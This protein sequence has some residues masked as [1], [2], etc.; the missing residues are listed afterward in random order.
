M[1]CLLFITGIIF[2]NLHLNAQVQVRLSNTS[3]FTPKDMIE[4]IFLG[5]G[6]EVL[7]VKY[8][9]ENKSTGYFSNGMNVISLE[10]GIIM[11]TGDAAQASFP[12]SKTINSST[13]SGTMFKDSELSKAI[14]STELNDIS[15]FEI[16]F[17]P[18][19]DTISF[20]Y[21]FASEEYPGYSCDKYN[22]V[23]GFFISG[24]DPA[25]GFYE[26]KNVALIPGTNEAVSINN[27]HPAYLNNCTA[28]NVEFYNENP[29]GSH[30]MV[31]NGYLDVFSASARVVPCTVY[32]IKIAIADVVDNLYDSAVFLEAKSFSAAGMNVTVETPSYDGRIAEGCEPARITFKF[33]SPVKEDIN[34]NLKLI[35]DLTLGN[36]A[37]AIL[38]F[39]SIPSSGIIKKGDSEFSFNLFALNDNLAENEEVVAIEYQKDLCN[40]DTI[41]LRISDNKLAKIELQDSL[42]LCQDNTINVG[43][44]LPDNYFPDSEKF[45][46]NKKEY[47]IPGSKGSTVSSKVTVAN[48]YPGF[49]K[50]EM[51]KEICIDRLFG[52]NLYDLDIYLVSPDNHFIELSSDNGFRPGGVSSVDSMI[53]T[54]FSVNASQSINNGNAVIGQYFPLNPNYEGY[55][56]PEGVWQDLEGVKVNGDWELFFYKDE[57]GWTNTLESW[58]MSFNSNYSLSYDWDPA[59]DISCIDCL[60]PD[61]FPAQSRYYT[62]NLKDTYGCEAKDSIFADVNKSESITRIECDSVSTD[63]IRFS[64]SSAY[65]DDTYELNLNNSGTWIQSDS[66]F[67]EFTGLGFSEKVQIE[68]RVKDNYCPNPS[69]SKQCETFPCPPPQVRILNKKDA[70]CYGSNNGEIVV[71]AFGTKAPYL[72][73]LNDIVQTTGSYVGLGAGEDTIFIMDGFACEI[74]FVFEIFSP[75]PISAKISK[76]DINCFGSNDGKI[77]T[78]VS[79]GNGNYRYKWYEPVSNIV[80]SD[81]SITGLSSGKYYLTLEDSKNCLLMD[82]IEIIE[83]EDLNISDSI[84]HIKCKGHNTGKIFVNCSGGIPPYSYFWETPVGNSLVRDLINVPAGVYKLKLTDSNGC[85]KNTNFLITEPPT[86]FQITY[87]GVDT[88]CYGS[89]NGSINLN[90]PA[91]PVYEIKWNGGYSG[92]QLNNIGKGIYS[93][94]LTDNEGCSYTKDIEIVELEP[95]NFE[96]AHNPP[97]C[98]DFSD[99]IA[100]VDAVYYGTRET[101]KLK[102]KFTWDTP[103][104]Q[105]GQYAYFLKGGTVYTVTGINEFLCESKASIEISN[106]PALVTQ[107]KSRRDVSCYGGSDAFIEIEIPACKGCHFI[108][109]ENAKTDDTTIAVNLKSGIYKLTVVDENGCL[110]E[111]TYSVT[112]PP[113]IDMALK[114][115]DVKCFN[116]ID[117]QATIKVTGGSPPY[118]V[119]W[120]DTLRNMSIENLASG[121]H[122]VVVTDINNCSETDTFLVDQPDSPLNGMAESSDVSCF[123]GFD[124]QIIFS[125][126]GGSPPYSF[127]INN[128]EFHGINTIIGLKS[129]IYKGTIKDVNG[130]VFNLNDIVI[131]DGLQLIVDLGSDTVV[132]Y[133]TSLHILPELNYQNDPVKYQWIVPESVNI[134]CLD[135]KYPVIEIEFNTSVKLIVTDANGCSAEDIKVIKAK[136]E[137]N[138]Y[139]PTAFS[140]KSFHTENS[141]VFVYGKSGIKIISFIIFDKWGGEVYKRENFDINDESNGWDGTFKG[142]EL[143]PGTFPWKLEIIHPDGTTEVLKGIVTLLN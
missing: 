29:L 84:V 114:I 80:F 58:H 30:S 136:L 134:S 9:G 17:I 51:L 22:D 37:S 42:H 68:I 85:S 39:N 32:K 95:V 135:C 53:N 140:P 94:T 98:H 52:R 8:D 19:F 122:K 100:W 72:Y 112:E 73:R 1:R 82:S 113:P 130:C 25:G 105:T 21:V 46:Q 106:P 45:F 120:N 138:V 18:F 67:Y 75:T 93:V 20:R 4:N 12:N 129:G 23:F 108:W 24:Q 65:N 123:N 77:Q 104:P 117:G 6:V 109:S 61:I 83:P 63:F 74:P 28:K 60:S 116:G 91:E 119:I 87:S 142:E 81:P 88:L 101:D 40:V 13:S 35:N 69:L 50:L 131:S 96:L 89:K 2:C 107:I 139:V 111:N 54:C 137:K 5:E 57:E 90:L 62:I 7:D 99:G 10:R 36:I 124:G 103:A 76:N 47:L 121:Y 41:I 34:L 16:T 127:R 11:T 115:E 126:E 125:A 110:S 43:A 70:D 56:T 86:G 59:T 44:K 78:E 132:D 15:R 49:L 102:F 128:E 118:L 97:S 38:D 92:R 26:N 71:E 64:W 133:G 66:H 141:R 27:V 33:N 79:G 14:G 3:N 31:Y 48:I 55:F 143:D